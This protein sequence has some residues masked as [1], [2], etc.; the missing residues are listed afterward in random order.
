MGMLDV[1]YAGA[2][3]DQDIDQHVDYTFGVYDIRFLVAYN[4]KYTFVPLEITSCIPL[5]CSL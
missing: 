2:Y 5:D 1:V 4:C 3:L